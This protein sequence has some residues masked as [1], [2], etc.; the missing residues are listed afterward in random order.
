MGYQV[1]AVGKRFGGYCVPAVC[2]QPECNK[3][4]DRGVSYACGDEPFSEF[5]CDLYFCEEHINDVYF[6]G[7]ERCMSEEDCDCEMIRLC[8]RCKDNK[9][10]FP[11]KPETKEWMKHL[12]KDKSWKKWRKENPD[13]VEEYKKLTK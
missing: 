11:Y 5:G 9:T 8:D 4:I 13:T 1:Y 6:N 7:D 3:E 2:E 12:L 10:P